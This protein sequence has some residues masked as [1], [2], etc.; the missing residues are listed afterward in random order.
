[1]SI[2]AQMSP[3]QC[4][5]MREQML[6]QLNQ[7]PPPP[8][9]HDNQLQVLF[10]DIPITG[11]DSVRRDSWQGHRARCSIRRDSW[12]GLRA[13]CSIRRDSGQGHRARF[14]SIALARSS[15]EAV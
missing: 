14:L 2:I 6:E 12:Q 5:Q 13:R 9:I 8:T 15:A 7:L 10:A 1:M 3:A 4:A 11:D